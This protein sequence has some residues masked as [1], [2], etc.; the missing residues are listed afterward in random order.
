MFRGLVRSLLPQSLRERIYRIRK[1]WNPETPLILSP[2]YAEDGLI[3][4]HV[5]DFMT[6]NAFSAAYKTGRAG[7]NWSHPGEIR[8]RAYIACWA[9]Q[10]AL[11]IDGDFVECG[12]AHGVLSRT[13]CAYVDF[14][15]V[16]KNFYL[17]DTFQ[18]IPVETLDDMGE[19]KNATQ[20]NQ[21]H[22]AEDLIPIVKER[23]NGYPNVSI[24]PGIL[25]ESLHNFSPKKIAYL[26]ID[27]NNA[28]AEIGVIKTLWDRLSPGAIVL[29]D[30]YAYGPEFITQKKA[31]DTFAASKNTPLLT[32][33]TGQGLI[34]KR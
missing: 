13:V 23:F 3:S 7:I 5:C 12:V 17:Y 18:G 9:A 21:T 14:Q 4:Q 20:F 11:N 15:N 2:A 31:W 8:F 24:N 34:L 1:A 29:L 6:D 33:P 26:S 30:D 28:K 27:L 22:Y 10:H 19:I 25:P 32:L 16:N